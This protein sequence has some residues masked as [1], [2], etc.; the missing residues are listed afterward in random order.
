MSVDKFK[1]IARAMWR[2]F[3]RRGVNWVDRGSRTEDAKVHAAKNIAKG[4]QGEKWIL[5]D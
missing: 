4:A 5:G 1:S 2:E 3:G